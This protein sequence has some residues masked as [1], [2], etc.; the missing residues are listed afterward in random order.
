MN[1]IKV[2]KSLLPNQI[3]DL[4]LEHDIISFNL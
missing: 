1:L 4:V 2:H 3:I